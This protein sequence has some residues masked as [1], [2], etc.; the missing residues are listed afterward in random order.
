MYFSN[1]L[2]DVTEKQT[3][4]R[5]EK[6]FYSR[7]S[8]FLCLFYKKNNFFWVKIVCWTADFNRIYYTFNLMDF[9]QTVKTITIGVRV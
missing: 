7:R 1:S 6:A 2:Q 5:T 3:L 9:V 8:D 4:N